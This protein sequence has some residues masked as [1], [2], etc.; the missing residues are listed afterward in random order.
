MGRALE[1]RE[2]RR[3]LVLDV[4]ARG[5]GLVGKREGGAMVPPEVSYT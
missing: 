3:V 2:E 1:D 5:T 4:T